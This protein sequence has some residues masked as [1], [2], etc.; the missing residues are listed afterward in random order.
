M[1]IID[2]AKQKIT[3]LLP[4]KY[5]K[6]QSYNSNSNDNIGGT[7]SDSYRY[8]RLVNRKTR[9]LT[10]K[11]YQ[12]IL[13]DTQVRVG[14]AILKYF[15]ISKNYNLTSD[16]D[17]PLD[18]EIRDFVQDCFDN[19]NISF[20]DVVMNILT[21]IPY[22]YS[23]QEKV[24]TVRDGKIVIDSLYPIHRKTI[25][26]DPFVKD[27]KGNLIAIHQESY[28]GDV[29]IPAD[30]CI[31]YGFESE[32][33]EIEG[34]SILNGIKPI[35]EDK[36]DI[37][38]WYMTYANRLGSPIMYG[39]TDDENHANEMLN[40]FDDVADGTTGL[41]VGLTDELGVIE[42][43]SKGEIY[44]NLL[45]YKDN[46]IFRSFFIGNL[47][48]GDTS[49]TGSY[50]QITG[51][52]DFMLYIMNGILTDVAGCLQRVI[53]DLV[54]Y[55][56]GADARAPNISF[57]NFIAKDI[58]GLMNTLK[59]FIDNGSFDSDNQGFKELLGKAF[60]SQADIKLDLNT[61]TDTTATLEDETNFDYQPPLE[62]TPN[63]EDVV[64]T[65]LEGIV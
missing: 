11:Q 46:Q 32:F 26:K 40:S 8:I 4:S 37:M 33:D 12:D 60:M 61:I 58:L 24:Y 15:L 27:N 31:V 65:V 41:V 2:K 18:I 16:S 64:N 56:Y 7:G 50:A 5:T 55:N 42:T 14:W 21:A 23:V 51:Q 10:Y 3:D 45:Q 38:D 59:G 28:Y 20:R 48:L 17:D 6:K 53:N 9:N 30:K 63:P 49:Q 29:D 47:L 34:N 25:D 39:K 1:S 36:E 22:G 62:G 52:Q 54:T 44:S 43:G 57:E 35:T 19:M 13:K